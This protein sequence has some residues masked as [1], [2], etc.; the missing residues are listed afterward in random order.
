MEINLVKEEELE[1][2]AKIYCCSFNYVSSENWTRDAALKLFKYWFER[3]Q[4]LFFVA[5]QDN[6]IIGAIVALAKPW[7][8]G[9][10]LQDGEVFVSPEYQKGGIGKKLLIKLIEEGIRKYDTN[11]FE[12]ITFAREEF[13]FSWYERIG[14]KKSDNLMVISGSCKEILNNLK[15]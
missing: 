8:D 1:E 15:K 13:P 4:D 6:K 12:G 9:V 3:Q 10:R 7:F 5:R 14:I 2:I 11:T